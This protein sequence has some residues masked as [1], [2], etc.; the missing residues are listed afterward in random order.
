[1]TSVAIGADRSSWVIT[2]NQ[3]GFYNG[4]IPAALT[5][6]LSSFANNG[7]ITVSDVALGANDSWAVIYNNNKI[8]AR[9]IDNNL[10]NFVNDTTGTIQTGNFPVNTIALGQLT[11]SYALV[12]RGNVPFIGTLTRAH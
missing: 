10:F 3:N 7:T 2:V 4:T 9:N 8:V 6:Q 5:Q 12:Y 1:V 11:S